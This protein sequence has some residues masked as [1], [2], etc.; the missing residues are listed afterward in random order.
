MAEKRTKAAAPA[1]KAPKTN[2]KTGFAPMTFKDFTITQKRSGRYEVVT[3]AGKNINGADKEKVLVEAKLFKAP[4]KKAPAVEEA[5][6][7]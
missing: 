1:Q 4:V 2:S 6:S 3:A 5:P 7:T